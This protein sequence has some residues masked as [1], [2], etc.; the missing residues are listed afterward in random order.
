MFAKLV[1]SGPIP[2]STPGSR[3]LTFTGLQGETYSIQ[4]SQNLK[5]WI[6][7]GTATAG[8]DGMVEFED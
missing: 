3:S 4:A 5:V 7:L 1:E 2:R 6:M 8:G